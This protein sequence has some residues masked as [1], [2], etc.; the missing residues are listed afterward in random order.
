M[1]SPLNDNNIVEFQTIKPDPFKKL[2]EALKEVIV[3]VNLIFDLDGLKIYA[4]NSHKTALVFFKIKKDSLEHYYVKERFLAG[5]NIITFFKQLKSGQSDDILFM[6]VDSRYSDTMGITYT[7]GFRESCAKYSLMNVDEEEHFNQKYE[8][9]SN[10][11][12]RANVL[13]DTIKDL[14]QITKYI[15]IKSIGHQLIFSTASIN[16]FDSL[17]TKDITIKLEQDSISGNVDSDEI[18]QGVFDI[19]LIVRFVKSTT[20]NPNG[21]V[22]M[23]LKNDTPLILEYD[24][25]SLGLLRFMIFQKIVD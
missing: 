17:I 6:N 22:K 5:I 10:I 19:E 25:S 7:S 14:A 24:I 12:V 20:I 11:K 18:I 8:Y 23:Y 9:S 21:F 16:D 15:E 2:F 1:E 3:D 4:M 13:Q